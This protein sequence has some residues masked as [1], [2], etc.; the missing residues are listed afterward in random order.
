MSDTVDLLQIK[1]EK[2][3]RELP[4]ET[5]NAI[6]AVDWR[7]AILGLRDKYGYTF[8][9]LGDLEI[10]TE[11]LLCGL[12][13]PDDY[14]KELEKRMN[15][16]RAQANELV[17][18]MNG[19]VFRKIREELIKNTERKKIFQKNLGEQKPQESRE[20]PTKP[21]TPAIPKVQTV[22]TGLPTMPSAHIM[23]AGKLELTNAENSKT[24]TPPILAQKLSGNFQTKVVETEHTLDNLT[25]SNKPSPAPKIDPYREVPE[26]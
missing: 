16:S 18:E 14:P 23:Q 8:E 21:D 25:P 1:I 5:A 22:Q 13:S 12:V 3:K 26:V 19:L 11:L 17:N 10:E 20:I 24:E 9:Q 2:A 7:A 6:A 15:I 4:V